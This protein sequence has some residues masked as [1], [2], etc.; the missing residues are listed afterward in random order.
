M[1]PAVEGLTSDNIEELLNRP[2]S[3]ESIPM[4]DGGRTGTRSSSAAH[5]TLSL[6]EIVDTAHGWTTGKPL[7]DTRF[8]GSERKFYH[9]NEFRCDVELTQ[10]WV[11]AQKAE[12]PNGAVAVF[13]IWFETI[14]KSVEEPQK[15][16][17]K[18]WHV[19][20]VAPNAPQQDVHSDCDPKH[21]QFYYT[22]VLPLVDN[23]EAGGTVFQNA[24]NNQPQAPFP[25]AVMFH[26]HVWHYGSQNNRDLPRY[27]FYVAIWPNGDADDP[28]LF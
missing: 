24:F 20:Y 13:E 7:P 14:L 8:V 18:D 1:Q 10:G 5:V 3:T 11:D 21:Q 17:R 9:L 2:I 23:I 19:Q 25:G 16:W 6:K 15:G 28:G 22:A 27:F 26:G 4:R 12:R